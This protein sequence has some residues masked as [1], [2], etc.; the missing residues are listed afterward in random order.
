MKRKVKNIKPEMLDLILKTKQILYF[1]PQ[2]DLLPNIDI[3]D[4]NTIH[5][6]DAINKDHFTFSIINVKRDIDVYPIYFIVYID[7]K[8]RLRGYTPKWGNLYNPWTNSSFG[9]ESIL[10]NSP[11]SLAYMPK[12][13]IREPNENEMGM[14]VTDEYINEFEKSELHVDINQMINEFIHLHEAV[15]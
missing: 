15:E 6:S 2:N 14:Q 4:I 5:I 3:S 10:L 1:I 8:N 13:Y 7:E 9:A 12:K 11:K